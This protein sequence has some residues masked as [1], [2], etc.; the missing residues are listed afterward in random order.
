MTTSA[1]CEGNPLQAS[2]V[3]RGFVVSS[4]FDEGALSRLNAPGR[5]KGSGDRRGWVAPFVRRLRLTLM[6]GQSMRLARTSVPR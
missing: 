1:R 5:L 2:L 6:R 3:R 4:V